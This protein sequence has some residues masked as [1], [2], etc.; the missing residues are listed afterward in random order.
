MDSRRPVEAPARQGG[1]LDAPIPI[2]ITRV[3]AAL[4]SRRFRNRSPRGLS[5]DLA[6]RGGRA[7]LPAESGRAHHRTS[8]GLARGAAR[9]TGRAL[10]CWRQALGPVVAVETDDDGTAD[11]LECDLRFFLQGKLGP[12][13]RPLI[14]S[15]QNE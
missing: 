1:T 7:R 4:P 13:D 12:A 10:R 9:G 8:T 2:P 15:F 3:L 5:A 14:L 11:A 6:E